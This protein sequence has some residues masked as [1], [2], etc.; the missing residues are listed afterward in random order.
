M[1]IA[2]SLSGALAFS[3]YSMRETG[4]ID[5]GLAVPKVFK[6]YTAIDGS[7]T[8][9]APVDWSSSDRSAYPSQ[10]SGAHFSSGDASVD[11]S[12]VGVEQPAKDMLFGVL[13]EAFVRKIDTLATWGRSPI[14]AL[15][16]Q[17]R[18]T[19]ASHYQRY[20]EREPETISGKM[21]DILVSEWTAESNNP[22]SHRPLHGYHATVIEGDRVY[23]LV[24]SCREED[25][26]RLW[27]DFQRMIRSQSSPIAG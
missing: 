6:T 23:T 7:F 11:V 20:V 13:K 24:C 2:L 16:K 21:G 8:C 14:D 1:A 4:V 17:S 25:W 3:L 26:K 18:E 10:Y 15:H 9:E 12:S 19:I 22:I 5:Q 27:F